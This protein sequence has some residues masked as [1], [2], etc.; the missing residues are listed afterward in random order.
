MN[1][2]NLRDVVDNFGLEEVSCGKAIDDIVIKTSEINRPGLQLV[3]Y[4]EHFDTERIQIIGNVETAYLE[5]LTEQER[6][7]C[8]DGFFKCGFPCIVVARNLEV[9]FIN[10]YILSFVNII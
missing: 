1:C 5:G 4:Y 3:K 6:T 7:E 9:M 2:V 10:R 8:L